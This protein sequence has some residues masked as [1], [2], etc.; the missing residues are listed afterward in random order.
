MPIDPQPHY[1][2]HVH[3]ASLPIQQPFVSGPPPPLP[4]PVQLPPKWKS[5]KD[6]E[7]RTY[8]YH[9]K[10]RIS[11]WEPPQWTEADQQP[12]SETSS[13]SS[14]EDEDEEEEDESSS[15][16]EEEEVEQEEKVKQQTSIM[17]NTF[18]AVQFITSDGIMPLIS[19]NLS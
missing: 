2:H 14:D 17:F 19:L 3:P 1:H 16:E 15:T 7:G 6:S 12:D 11:Q 18:I 8:Y 4:P 5:A 13:E 10:T 9:V